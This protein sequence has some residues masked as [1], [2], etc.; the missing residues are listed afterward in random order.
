MMHYKK[1]YKYGMKY[2]KITISGKICTGKSTLLKKLQ[3]HLSWKVFHAGQYFRDYVKKHD[4]VLNQ[5]EEQNEK[6]TKKVDYSMRDLLKVK[7]GNLIFD[8]WMAGIMADHFPHV[9]RVLLVCDDN[10][11]AKR[12]AAREKVTITEA[13]K[14]ITQ[15]HT[16]WISKVEKIYQRNDFFDPINY[17]CIIDTTKLSSKEVFNKVMKCI[18]NENAR[19]SL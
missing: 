4:L 13:K 1:D 11:R 9:L 5:A 19:D 10:K 7:R 17:N 12:F 6:L 16:S 2:T 15:R 18:K 14:S 8:S 3:K